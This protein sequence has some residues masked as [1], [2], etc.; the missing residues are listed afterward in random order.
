MLI[1][2]VSLSQIRKNPVLLK[3]KNLKQT[4]ISTNYEFLGFYRHKW[5]PT[6][7]LKYVTRITIKPA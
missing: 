1:V 4:N 5:P 2:G 6:N 7:E 3:F